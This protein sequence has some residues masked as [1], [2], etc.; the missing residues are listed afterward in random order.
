MLK[1]VSKVADGSRD[2][3]IDCVSLATRWGR[4]V[5]FIEDEER[6]TAEVAKP[7]TK[8]CGVGFVD[9]QPMRD[10]KPR[11]RAPRVNAE[12][13]FAADS[14]HVLLVEDLESESEA[15]FEFILPLEEHR[16]RAANDDFLRLLP[17]KQFSGDQ[18]R[19]NGLTQ[20]DVIS[21]EEVDPWKPKRLSQWLKLVCVEL[22]PGAK[23]R[24]K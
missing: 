14:F 10:K 19:F 23:R 21:D 18:P 24:L 16:G 13:S 6:S 3:R 4:M 17:Q 8:R 22:N 7:V 5:G 2:L 1:A 9:Q 11:V 12:S 20:T 15:N